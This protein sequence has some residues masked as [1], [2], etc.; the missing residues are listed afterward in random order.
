MALYTVLLLRY[1]ISIVCFVLN[2]GMKD[3][4][5]IICTHIDLF[6][7]IGRSSSPYYSPWRQCHGLILYVGAHVG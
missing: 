2:C 5:I 4:S 3:T 1:S 7:V 6:S